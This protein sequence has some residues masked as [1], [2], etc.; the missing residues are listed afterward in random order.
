MAGT[1][2]AT[3]A[4]GANIASTVSGGIMA[5]SS[6]ALP[7]IAVG[8]TLFGFGCLGYYFCKKGQTKTL[9]DFSK[10]SSMTQLPNYE[11]IG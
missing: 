2:V 9:V 1:V 4:T 7:I 11:K 3:G 8:G 10:E 5:A 6:V